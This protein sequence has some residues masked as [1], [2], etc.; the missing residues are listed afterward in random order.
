MTLSKAYI[1][2]KDK[3]HYIPYVIDPITKSRRLP[4]DWTVELDEDI[5]IS[6]LGLNDE[7]IT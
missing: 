1:K 4:D 2:E 7:I 6:G 3:V 5:N